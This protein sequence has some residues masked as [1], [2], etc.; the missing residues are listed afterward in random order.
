MTTQERL[1]QIAVE[2][3]HEILS[4]EEFISYMESVNNGSHTFVSVVSL[5]EAKMNKTNNPFYGRVQKLSKWSCCINTNNK[6]KG[7][8]L[9]EKTG[10]SDKR[11]YKPASTYVKSTT[12]VENYVVCSKKDNPNLKYLRVYT[13]P[14]S[15]ES[16]FT[17]YYIDGVKATTLEVEQI[18]SF[19]VKSSKGSHNLGVKGDSAYGVFNLSI[20]NVKYMYVCGRKIK[21]A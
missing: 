12:D 14:D 6:T 8:N 2:I 17:E 3:A 7:D 13:N 20:D 4:K 18:K 15:N 10:V 5:T 9:R 21:L 19:L 11:D 1:N 16:T